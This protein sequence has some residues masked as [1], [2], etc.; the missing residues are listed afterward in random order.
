MRSHD[1]QKRKPATPFAVRWI[2]NHLTASAEDRHGCHG[3]DHVE[4]SVTYITIRK[5]SLARTR[6]LQSHSHSKQALAL[7]C[8]YAR[9][10][11]IIADC[12][13]VECFAPETTLFP[14]SLPLKMGP[15]MAGRSVI[16]CHSESTAHATES[17]KYFS[18][19]PKTKGS[20]DRNH[21]QLL[22]AAP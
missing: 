11:Y 6:A 5:N 21:H 1:L 18:S 12:H 16:L 14:S 22:L 2:P 8:I 13:G 17:H 10:Y 15:S 3:F 20:K 9:C 4:E 19:L 7:V